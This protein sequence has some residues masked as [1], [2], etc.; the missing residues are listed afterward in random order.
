V[1]KHGGPQADDLESLWLFELLQKRP[2]LLAAMCLPANWVVVW[3]G[4]EIEGI[5]DASNREVW[6]NT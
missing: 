6:K 5:A 3:N 4:T 2:H 1:K